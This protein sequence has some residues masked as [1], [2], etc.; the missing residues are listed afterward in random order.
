[1]RKVGVSNNVQF[2]LGNKWPLRNQ[3]DV[4]HFHWAQR[5]FC[6]QFNH[7]QMVLSDGSG[8]YWYEGLNNDGTNW[9]G[10][11]TS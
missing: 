2:I 10:T 9:N 5:L 7:H 1:M 4:F 11:H 6:Y 8:P 3:N